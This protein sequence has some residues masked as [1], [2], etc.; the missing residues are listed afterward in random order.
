MRYACILFRKKTI[1]YSAIIINNNNNKKIIKE[2]N[3]LKYS[4]NYILN[5]Y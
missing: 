2:I 1:I 5:N 3:K 4:I